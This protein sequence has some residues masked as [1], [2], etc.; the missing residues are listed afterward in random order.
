METH[1][2]TT[3]DYFFKLVGVLHGS[4]N[5][6]CAIR[7]P[8]SHPSMFSNLEH[9]KNFDFISQWKDSYNDFI[10][11]IANQ[12]TFAQV[13]KYTT[14]I[15]VET[16]NGQTVLDEETYGEMQFEICMT[17]SNNAFDTTKIIG[18]IMRNYGVNCTYLDEAKKNC[19]GGSNQ[20]SCSLYNKMVAKQCAGRY[21]N[22]QVGFGGFGINCTCK[23]LLLKDY[24][25]SSY[26][27]ISL[28]FELIWFS[29]HPKLH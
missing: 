7:R 1:S 25:S 4:K 17:M 3:S 16:E 21:S 20:K 22:G 8:T 29:V 15:N 5:K 13:V 14:N 26:T 23:F 6:N 24:V 9:Q 28:H 12:N 11:A 19:L 2:A 27:I 18:E 10:N